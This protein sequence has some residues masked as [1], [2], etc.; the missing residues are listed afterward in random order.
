M[1][2]SLAVRAMRR[3]ISPRLAIRSDVMG[4][5]V[6]A[7]AEIPSSAGGYRRH[8]GGGDGRMK[9]GVLEPWEGPQRHP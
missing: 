6:V 5:T 9:V 7:E 8:R 1:P 3:A 2:I 4:V